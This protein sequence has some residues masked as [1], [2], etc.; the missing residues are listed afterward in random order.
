MSPA[1]DFCSSALGMVP[2]RD[3]NTETGR[4][5]PEDPPALSDVLKAFI[6]S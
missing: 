1:Q 5:I 3:V 2:V 4:G 6:W